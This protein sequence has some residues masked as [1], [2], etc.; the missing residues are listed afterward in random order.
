[1]LNKLKYWWN[2]GGYVGTKKNEVGDLVRIYHGISEDKQPW[3]RRFFRNNKVAISVVLAS[4]AS[5]LW[6]FQESINHYLINTYL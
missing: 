4:T 1:M 6:Y 2:G 5:V 3:I